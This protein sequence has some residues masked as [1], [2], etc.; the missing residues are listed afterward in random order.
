MGL[1]E[2]PHEVDAPDIED[3]HLQVVVEGH[4]VASSDA[5]LQLAFSTPLDEFLGVFVHC[6]LEEPALLYFGLCAE[7][8]VM[9]SV[10]CCMAFFNDVQ[11]FCHWYTSPQ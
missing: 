5:T 6:W 9:A 3:L 2:W 10:R 8:S 4:C 7:Y 11:S 1:L